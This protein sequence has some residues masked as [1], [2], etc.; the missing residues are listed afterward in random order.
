MSSFCFV[1]GKH[2]EK[3]CLS[4]FLCLLFHLV[5]PTMLTLVDVDC[6]VVAVRADRSVRACLPR[7][8]TDTVDIWRMKEIASQ[9]D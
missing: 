3:N 2:E 6:E 5:S 8:L 9:L 4:H 7:P 1:W